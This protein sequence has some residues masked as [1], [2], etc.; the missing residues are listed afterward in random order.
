M[1]G[2]NNTLA[3]NAEVKPHKCNC[4]SDAP[5]KIS[6]RCTCVPKVLENLEAPRGEITTEVDSQFN[7][8]TRVSATYLNE[9]SGPLMFYRT[10]GILA[11]PEMLNEAPLKKYDASILVPTE[12][13]DRKKIAR[14]DEIADRINRFRDPALLEEEDFLA[15]LREGYEI[16]LGRDHQRVSEITTR[17]AAA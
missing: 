1:L 13:A 8:E 14:L 4:S 15:A 11:V 12:G 6:G 17:G 2:N 16:V 3:I 7:Q 10:R 9:Y 5:C